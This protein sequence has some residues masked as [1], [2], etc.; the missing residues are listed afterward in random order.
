VFLTGPDKLVPGTA[1]PA[2]VPDPIERRNLI[3]YLASVSATGQ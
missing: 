2:T 3:A 1:M